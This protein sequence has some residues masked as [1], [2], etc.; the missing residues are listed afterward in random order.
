MW[1]RDTGCTLRESQFVCKPDLSGKSPSSISLNPR[2]RDVGEG[3]THGCFIE[4]HRRGKMFMSG[5]DFAIAPQFT[6]DLAQRGDETL[7]Q[8]LPSRP[9]RRAPGSPAASRLGSC[10][11]GLTA[12]GPG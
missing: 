11:M 3:D 1:R 5:R 7:Q 12:L 9:T 6:Q 4:A 2:I 10:A 8:S